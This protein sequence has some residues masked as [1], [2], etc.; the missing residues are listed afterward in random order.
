M[1][2]GHEVTRD[3]ALMDQDYVIGTVLAVDG[4]PLVAP[5]VG[6]RPSRVAGVPWSQCPGW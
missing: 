4:G 1:T 6:T 3:L 2:T 5:G